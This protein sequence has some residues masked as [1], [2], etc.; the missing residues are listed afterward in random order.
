[1]AGVRLLEIK[2]VLHDIECELQTLLDTQ[3][4]LFTDV[5]IWTEAERRH[6]RRYH[7]KDGKF[8]NFN[9]QCFARMRSLEVGPVTY[10]SV[11]ATA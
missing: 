6:A 2:I 9:D 1:M 7:G 11:I 3:A 5:E 4:R 8:S 10:F